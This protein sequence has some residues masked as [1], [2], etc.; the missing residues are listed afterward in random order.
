MTRQNDKA[1]LAF[2]ALVS[3]LLSWLFGLARL[4]RFAFWAN[5]ALLARL[6][7]C[8]AV[9]SFWVFVKRRKIHTLI[10][11]ILRYAQYDKSPKF[12]I[13]SLLQKGEKSILQKCNLHFK[14]KAEFKFSLLRKLRKMDT[15]LTLSMTR[16]NDKQALLLTRFLLVAKVL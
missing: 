4:A 7:F 16:Q 5:F 12:V 14:F 13:L 3:A 2:V 10:L 6:A 11:W 15:S 1:N 9:L 8:H